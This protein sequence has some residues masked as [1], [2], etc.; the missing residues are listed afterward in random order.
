MSIVA[1]GIE[2]PEQLA[3]LRELGGHLAQGYLLGAPMVDDGVADLLNGETRGLAGGLNR[4]LSARWD[5]PAR[6]IPG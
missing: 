3:K 5:N 1:E 2:R 6:W 4:H